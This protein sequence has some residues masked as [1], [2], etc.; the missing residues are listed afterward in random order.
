LLC[1]FWNILSFP[2]FNNPTSTVI[3]T[4]K[5]NLL[6]ARIADDGQWR[7]PQSDSVPEKFQTA[8]KYFED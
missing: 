8:I 2:L 1:L 5:G 6:A 7:F 3:T 4:E